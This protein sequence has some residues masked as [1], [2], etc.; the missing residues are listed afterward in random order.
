[1]TDRDG[2][3]EKGFGR[4]QLLASLARSPALAQR[5]ILLE[6]D[7]VSQTYRTRDG[8]S[9]HAVDGVSCTIGQGEFVALLGL[10]GCGKSTLLT[11]IA[12]LLRPTASRILHRG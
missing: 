2:C 11:M 5:P 6:L 12:G 10:S 7:D 1:L 3:G 9:V 8:G 4:I